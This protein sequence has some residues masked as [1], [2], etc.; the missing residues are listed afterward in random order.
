MVHIGRELSFL[1]EL[2]LLVGRN[3]CPVVLVRVVVILHII[4]TFLLDEVLYRLDFE[5]W[6]RPKLDHLLLFLVI[7]EHEHVEATETADLY[8]LL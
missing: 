1:L 2:C 8:S 4:L 3:E 7:D 5:V 6:I